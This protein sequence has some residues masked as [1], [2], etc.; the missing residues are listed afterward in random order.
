MDLKICVA[1]RFD[2][3]FNPPRLN[4]LT[5]SAHSIVRTARRAIAPGLRSTTPTLPSEAGETTKSLTSYSL[6]GNWPWYQR[7]AVN[8]R[9]PGLNGQPHQ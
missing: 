6:T 7:V 2:I 9:Y 5:D 1:T 3:N 8:G 4:C